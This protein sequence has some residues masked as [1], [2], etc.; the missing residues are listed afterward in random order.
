MVDAVKKVIKSSI[1]KFSKECQL[2][3]TQ[4]QIAISVSENEETELVYTLL[5]NHKYRRQISLLKDIIGI[6]FKALD[7]LNKEE[8]VNG[9]ILLAFDKYSKQFNV[10]FKNL[11]LLIFSTDMHAENIIGYLYEGQ[12]KPL[13]KISLEDLFNEEN[14]LQ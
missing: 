11:T 12:S 6:P 8:H 14:I 7:I 9:F 4:I 3:A 10:D 5:E 2:P 1:E 13:Q